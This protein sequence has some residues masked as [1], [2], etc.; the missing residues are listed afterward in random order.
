MYGREFFR[1]F[2]KL[3]QIL[4]I[5]LTESINDLEKG[6]VNPLLYPVMSILSKCKF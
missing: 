5:S 4:K 6:L 1:K 3:Y 2:P